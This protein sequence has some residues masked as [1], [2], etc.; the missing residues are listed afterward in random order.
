MMGPNVFLKA[1]NR[2]LNNHMFTCS[3]QLSQ[4]WTFVALRSW[5]LENRRIKMHDVAS[6]MCRNAG[7]VKTIHP[8]HFYSRKRPHAE[9]QGCRLSTRKH[10]VIVCVPTIWTR[11]HWR[12]T[13]LRNNSYLWRNISTLIHPVIKEWLYKGSPPPKIFKIQTSAGKIMASAFREL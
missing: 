6:K 8:W 11:L 5:F 7:S 13:H 4:V 10:H 12:E 9:S 2:T 3:Q 1:V